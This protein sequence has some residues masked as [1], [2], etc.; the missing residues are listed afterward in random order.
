MNTLNHIAH[1]EQRKELHPKANRVCEN[2]IDSINRVLG[3]PPIQKT[4]AVDTIRINQME[5]NIY[6]I[7][8]KINERLSLATHGE[9]RDIEE[10]LEWVSLC[11][12]SK[13]V[14]LWNQL[15]RAFPWFTDMYFD[16]TQKSVY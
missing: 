13:Y 10:L 9:I 1:Q 5:A 3:L 6:E 2:V 14:K 4:K 8:R 7:A 16:L 12:S 15:Q 11:K